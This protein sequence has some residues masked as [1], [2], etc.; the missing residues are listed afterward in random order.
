VTGRARRATAGSGAAERRPRIAIWGH[1]HGSNL[2]DDV[3]VEA[4]LQNLRRR[5]PDADFFGICLDPADTARRHGILAFPLRR[6]VERGDD[7]GSLDQTAELVKERFRGPLT[8]WPR[9]RA[10]AHGARSTLAAVRAAAQEPGFVLRSYR[11]LRGCD[12]VVVAGSGTVGDDWHGP[13]SHPYTI[14]KWTLIA[15][16]AGADFVF[17]SVGAGPINHRL[18]RLMLRP[19]IRMAAHQSYRDVS[20]ARWIE[21]ISSRN[22]TPRVVPDLAFSLEPPPVPAP[23]PNGP[24]TVGLNAIPFYDDR[25]WPR[26]DSEIYQAHLEKMAEFASWALQGG[27]R[28]VLLYSQTLADPR[29]ADDL[30]RLLAERGI[31]EDDPRIERPR[32]ETTSDLFAAIGRCDY[33]VAGR[34]HCILLPFMT[35]RPAIGLAYHQKS[36]DLVEYLGLPGFCFDVGT[37]E[38]DELRERALELEAIRAD[39]AA[40]AARRLP[41]LREVL[42]REYDEVNRIVQRRV[43]AGQ[44]GPGA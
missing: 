30:S 9:V 12:V 4:I 19:A 17:L 27:R 14:L 11:R 15:R 38:V 33:L 31:P 1:Y 18:S 41:A 44:P 24:A 16:A 6:Y 37:F 34:F 2:G 23:S 32:I 5:L 28:L 25:Y 7:S 29:V 35:G 43:A 20:S 40:E 22:G 39:A 21:R 3:V 13:W 8:R 10:A 36:F 26:S 42:D